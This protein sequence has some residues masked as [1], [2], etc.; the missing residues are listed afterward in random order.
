[1]T[2]EQIDEL[3]KDM[4]KAI[5]CLALE[6]PEAVWSE[7]DKRWQNLKAGYAA[8]PAYKGDENAIVDV[9]NQCKEYFDDKA[10]A[11]VDDGIYKPNKE[12]FKTHNLEIKQGEYKDF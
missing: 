8:A 7:I 6:L 10:D 9:L 5:R 3:T 12:I 2:Q 1:M 4:D 11:D